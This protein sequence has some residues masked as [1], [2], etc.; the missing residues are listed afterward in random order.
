MGEG[1]GMMVLVRTSARVCVCVCVSVCLCVCVSVCLC[2][3][4][5]VWLCG[6]VSV[7]YVATGTC[8]VTQMCSS[9]VPAA[10]GVYAAGGTPS[11]P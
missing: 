9:W 2:V 5:S 6:C 7:Y 8:T 11:P 4:V 10:V 3:C 1:A